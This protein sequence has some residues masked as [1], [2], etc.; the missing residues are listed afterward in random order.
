MSSR[1]PA[2]RV[3]AA[4]SAA[5]RKPAANGYAPGGEAAVEPRPAYDASNRR[6]LVADDD[7]SIRSLLVELLTDEGYEPMEAATG[8]EMLEIYRGPQRPALVL[9]DVQMPDMTGVEALR[10]I[11]QTAG[12]EQ[13]PIMMMTA[14]TTASIAI[15]ATML[16][17]FDYLHKPFDIEQ[18]IQKVRTFFSTQE[19]E[20][21]MAAHPT[22]GDQRLRD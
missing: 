9:M 4:G 7:E 1:P 22:E 12:G 10:E 5:S 18:V 17:A 3:S 6:V 2:R 11:S 8:K 14:F 16:G 21:Q 15:E 20:A 19:Q 13:L